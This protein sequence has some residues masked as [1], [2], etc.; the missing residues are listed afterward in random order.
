MIF[1]A[2]FLIFARQVA[3]F[4]NL[5]AYLRPSMLIYITYKRFL[6][7]LFP[8]KTV[9]VMPRQITEHRYSLKILK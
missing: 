3:V 8:A 4:Q 5:S 1:R 2:T 7:V 9:S 6:A